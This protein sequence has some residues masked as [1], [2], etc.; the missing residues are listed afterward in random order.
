[1]AIDPICGMEV[2]E[3]T[4]TKLEFEGT[5]YY[6]CCVH[7]RQ[8]F[9]DQQ[10]D[11][12]ET[13]TPSCCHETAHDHEPQETLAADA[14][15]YCPMC[16]GV[17]SDRPSACPKCGMALER[18][19]PTVSHE[20]F[21]PMH[22][23]IV[24]TESGNCPICGM[25]LEARV[26]DGGDDG[27]DESTDITR[28]FW[29]GAALMVPLFL[30][31]MG[32]MVGIP[33]NQFMGG[34][35]TAQLL[36]FGLGTVIVFWTGWPI[37]QL[38]WQ[39]FVNRQLNMFSL[40]GL[41]VF[42]AYFYSAIATCIPTL[43]PQS[44]KH[45]G[46]PQVYFEA[47]AMIIVLVLLGQVLEHRARRKTSSAIRSL[48]ALTP[49]T[50]RRFVDGVY[51]EVGLDAVKSQDRLQV[52]PGDRVPVDGVV[53][54]GHS[55][56]DES[57]ITGEPIAVEKKVGDEIIGGTINQEGML[58][59]EARAVGQDTMLAQ[60]V[61]L[62]SQAQRTHAPI[63]RVADRFSSWFVPIVMLVALAT[64]VMWA[65]FS[66]WEPRLAYALI[67]AV[68]V[69]IIACPCAL[70]L[71]AP[72][73]MTVAIG[74]AAQHGILIRD[75]AVLEELNEINALV[76][77]KTGT[78]TEGK[79]A[80]ETI[81]VAPSFENKNLT[82][83]EALRI[84]AAV[85]QN[86]EHPIAHAVF[87]AARKRELSLPTTTSFRADVGRGARAVVDDQAILIGSQAYMQENEVRGFNDTIVAKADQTRQSGGTVL[88]LAVNQHLAA[89][90]CVVDPV[91]PS[92]R[93]AL[94]QLRDLGVSITMLTGDNQMTATSVA[95][96][97]GIDSV[98]A[99][100]SPQEKHQYVAHLRDAGKRVAMAGDGINDAP[101][102]AAANVGIAMGTGTDIAIESAGV[103]LLHGDLGGI[104]TAIRLGHLTMRNIYQ[105]LF[106]AFIYNALGIPLASGV[107]ALIFHGKLLLNPMVAAAAMSL[108]SVSVITNALRL[109]RAH[110]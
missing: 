110:P 42:A 60:I 84:A 56:V 88:F 23:E 36:Q 58:E 101:A 43:I 71:A 63:Q 85:E 19:V 97:V 3:S 27:N 34:P 87:T 5:T 98:K 59:F 102:L 81:E 16:P 31:A 78:V 21:C 57:M 28:R 1:M 74:R 37:L 24:R 26:T 75:A 52:L 17:T 40:I 8:K 41:G 93:A 39:S 47:A 86:S 100:V 72:V 38:A 44:F 11:S 76:V 70:G 50:A 33:I 13:D 15:Y 95:A 54:D 46:Q 6:F 4:G 30:V 2:D 48:M 82:E 92:S 83:T 20:Y 35:R 79:P 104:V 65:Y 7:C 73:S 32:P 61:S 69:L 96:A 106:F 53:L 49:P 94:Q 77:D 80:L 99:E 68:A 67:N 12:A 105:N 22:P 14:A 10:T 9:I 18:T 103:T 29:I 107:L 91:K 109:K 90:L 108:S 62:V 89:T 64:F 66:P 25:A 51:Q 55:H 45:D